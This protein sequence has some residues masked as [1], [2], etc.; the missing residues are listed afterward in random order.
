MGKAKK[1][2]IDQQSTTSKTRL[3]NNTGMNSCVSEGLAMT[4]V[5]LYLVIY[6]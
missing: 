4:R 3:R 1:T 5:D 6:F 2:N